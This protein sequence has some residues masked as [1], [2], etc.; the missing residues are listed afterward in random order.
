MWFYQFWTASGLGAPHQ[1]QVSEGKS[2]LK[3]LLKMY[4]SSNI[5]GRVEL[6]LCNHPHILLMWAYVHYYIISLRAGVADN[7]KHFLLVLSEVFCVRSSG[8][9]HQD[10]CMFL[11]PLLDGQASSS[12]AADGHVPINATLSQSV[13][14]SSDFL[15]EESEQH[16]GEFADPPTPSPSLTVG[17]LTE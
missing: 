17:R 9:C 5:R 10:S 2:S 14:W 13:S 4:E 6:H 16:S 7:A 3:E 1:Y 11:L 12:S 8:S 15:S